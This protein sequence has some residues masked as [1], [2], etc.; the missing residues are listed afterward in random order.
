M[1]YR[2]VLVSALLI[3]ST[4]LSSCASHLISSGLP[5]GSCAAGN[6]AVGQTSIGG[7]AGL[8][9]R[10]ASGEVPQQCGNRPLSR[11]EVRRSFG[12]GLATVLT[13]GVVNPATIHFSC[14][15]DG[16]TSFISCE[17]IEGTA[18]PGTPTQI[19]CTKNSVGEDPVVINYDCS[20]TSSAS[21][22]DQIASF[23]CEAEDTAQLDLPR[24]LTIPTQ[25]RG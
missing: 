5:D 22:P 18:S 1:K 19:M 11:V 3:S 20:A 10:A 23:T 13:L 8:S 15:K 16:Q 6:C 17:T 7:R 12:Q 14:A 24:F 25:R 4:T 2:V 21:K 9:T